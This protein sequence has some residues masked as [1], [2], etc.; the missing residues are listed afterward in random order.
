MDTFIQLI[1]IDTLNYRV[2]KLDS[3][4]S[5]HEL[6]S[7]FVQ[8]ISKYYL[9]GGSF[10]LKENAIAFHTRLQ[11][12]GFTPEYIKRDTN[13]HTVAIGIYKNYKE[14]QMVL[15]QYLQLNPESDAWI[16]N[17]DLGKK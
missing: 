14:A 13:L 2:E 11:N 16:F 6:G 12:I 15:D 4:E 9:I 10:S 17:G 5:F 1:N 7:E 3:S 8:P